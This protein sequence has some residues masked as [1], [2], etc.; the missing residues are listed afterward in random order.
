MKYLLIILG[1]DHGKYSDIPKEMVVFKYI[2]STVILS[3]HLH[4][5][6]FKSVISSVLLAIISHPVSCHPELDSIER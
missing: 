6:F 3:N 1:D 2:R 4:E 5:G